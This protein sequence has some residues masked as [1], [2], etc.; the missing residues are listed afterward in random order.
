[1][2][3]KENEIKDEKEFWEKY[4]DVKPE[5]V[6]KKP[7]TIEKSMSQGVSSVFNLLEHE[8]TN[9]TRAERIAY[10]TLCD[11]PLLGIYVERMI[12][13]K[14]HEKAWFTKMLNRFWQPFVKAFHSIY[15][16]K[17]VRRA[18]RKAGYSNNLFD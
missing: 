18:L 5:I 12:K 9:L 6:K 13:T 16:S 2:E 8:V 3:N 7:N 14:R 4:K 11:D 17:Q 1:M 15:H 10:A